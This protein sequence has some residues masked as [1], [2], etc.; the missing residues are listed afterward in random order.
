MKVELDPAAAAQ[1]D[2]LYDRAPNVAARIDECLDWIEAEPMD[3]RAYR[4]MFSGG[5]RA[6]SR[7]ID[8]VEWLVLWEPD[9]DV[10][11]IRAIL[12]ADRL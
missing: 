3:P 12:P 7:A 11:A 9:G 4:R 2:E 6:I 10:A 5:I 1:L 8:D